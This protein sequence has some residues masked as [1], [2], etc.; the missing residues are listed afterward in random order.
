VVILLRV[1]FSPSS[2]KTS[3]TRM[4][5]MVP[6]PSF[7]LRSFQLHHSL[8][9]KER[10]E[11]A[12]WLSLVVVVV[13]GFVI[14]A[15]ADWKAG[16]LKPVAAKICLRPLWKGPGSHSKP[17]LVDACSASI[18]SSCLTS[19]HGLSFLSSFVCVLLC[20][21]WF[22]F[23]KPSFSLGGFLEKEEGTPPL[24]SLLP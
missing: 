20:S 23:V 19:A 18:F 21:C 12:D 16:A 2:L 3:D 9:N 10:R 7:L 5:P 6:N 15:V 11:K 13:V 8:L 22:L 4:R 14:V 17:S 24:R 1:S